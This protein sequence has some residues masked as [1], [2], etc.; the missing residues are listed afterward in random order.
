[1]N[2]L[3][4]RRN[5]KLKSNPEKVKDRAAKDVAKKK[6]LPKESEKRKQEKPEYEKAVNEVR[7]EANGKCQIKSPVCNPNAPHH[8]HHVY[9]RVGKNYK[10]KNRM[11][12]GCDPCNGYLEDHPE[13]AKAHGLKK[14][15][16][17][18]KLSK[19]KKTA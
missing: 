16:T 3:E 2:Y 15:D 13:F 14:L 12:W 18:S 6:P 11:I 19:F 8:S 7:K 17:E 1:M 4:Y 10:D 9:G 5:L